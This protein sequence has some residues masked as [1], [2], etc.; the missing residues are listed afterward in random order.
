MDLIPLPLPPPFEKCKI[1]QYWKAGWGIP[2]LRCYKY[3]L[4]D[5]WEDCQGVHELPA[6]I[7][8]ENGGQLPVLQE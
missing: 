5:S 6:L 1:L 2:N 3:V 8:N 7:K 4:A